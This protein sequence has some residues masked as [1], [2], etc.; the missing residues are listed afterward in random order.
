MTNI[1]DLQQLWEENAR[2]SASFD[3]A[4]QVGVR[5]PLVSVIISGLNQEAG[6]LDT[7]YS[8]IAQP[9]V[10]EIIVVVSRAFPEIEKKVNELSKIYARC[11]AISVDAHVGISAAFNVAAKYASGQFLLFL[12]PV[13][14]LPKKAIVKL[15][16]TGIYKS[17]PWLIGLEIDEAER[18]LS[19][20]YKFCAMTDLSNRAPVEVSLPGGG[21][22]AA[23]VAKHCLF[24]PSKTFYEL[25]GFDEACGQDNF[26]LDACL[27][28]HLMGGGVY[29]VKNLEFTA[30]RPSAPPFSKQ[31]WSC[32]WATFRGWVHFYKKHVGQVK[33]KLLLWCMYA[34]LGVSFFIGLGSRCR[35]SNGN[36]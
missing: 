5:Y 17:F 22:Y 35:G 26:H 28:V 36:T 11:C 24:I 4:S 16:S 1:I 7:I 15:L 25:N 9:Y 10:R 3:G 20:L 8:V 31:N 30:A 23:S 18:S 19:K 21:V 27:R 13:G 14:S 29:Q 6:L 34:V 12:E 33:S 2:R 32:T